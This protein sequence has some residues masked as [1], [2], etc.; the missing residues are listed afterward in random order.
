MKQGGQRLRSIVFAVL[1]ASATSVAAQEDAVAIYKDFL[2]H[3]LMAL[4]ESEIYSSVPM[5][6]MGAARLATASFGDLVLQANLNTLMYDG[7]ADYEN[8]K[9]AFQRDLGEEPTGQLTV[10]QISTLTYR[11]SRTNMTYVSFFPFD[12][13]GWK[14]D[15]FAFVEGT[16]KILDERIAQP[17]NHVTINCR[18]A[19]GICTYQQIA[20]MLPDE[21]SF[22]QSYSVG[23][24]ADESYQ[25]TR[26]ENDLIDAVPLQNNACRTNQLSFNF[27]TK[28]FFEIAKNNTAGDCKTDLGVTLPQLEKPRVSQIVDGREIIDAEFNALNKEAFSYFSSDFRKKIEAV[29]PAEAKE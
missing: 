5:N 26:W 10:W 8:A 22:A 14:T 20:L 19:D 2:P 29:A 3:E 24:I 6:L 17:I 4:P 25:I 28:E 21:N 13:G 11:S 16:V 9:K 12:F 1:L 18:R 27:A 15:D 23:Q 7:F